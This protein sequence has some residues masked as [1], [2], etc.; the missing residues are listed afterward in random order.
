MLGRGGSSYR[1]CYSQCAW[2]A[3][4][5][6]ETSAPCTPLRYP[7]VR[8]GWHGVPPFRG[9][10]Q[11]PDGGS[12]A[13]EEAWGAREVPCRMSALLSI[14]VRQATA[15]AVIVDNTDVVLSVCVRACA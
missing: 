1:P 6:E 13:G 8:D 7:A 3:M 15:P 5:H 9:R 11:R 4:R 10:C 14:Q 2:A 12:P